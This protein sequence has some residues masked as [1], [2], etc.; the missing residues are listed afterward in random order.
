MPDIIGVLI[1]MQYLLLAFIK[2]LKIENLNKFVYLS[3]K[4][5]VVGV[6]TFLHMFEVY[7][8]IHEWV[9]LKN[10]F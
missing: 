7:T 5:K 10:S 8:F 6:K 1:V 3:S 4:Q 9:L 2:L